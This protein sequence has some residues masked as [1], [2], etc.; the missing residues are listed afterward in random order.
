MIATLAGRRQ[1]SILLVGPESVGKTALV[2]EVAAR[3]HSG[4]VPPP[5]KD[6]QVWFVT[7]NDLI[8]GMKY[9]GEWEG[10]TQKLLA[11]TRAGHQILYMD[12]PRQIV[13]AGR[14]SESDNNMG[15]FLRPAIESGDLTVICACTSEAYE[16]SVRLEPSF[17]HAFH[18]IDVPETNE[19]DTLAILHAVAAARQTDLGRA[20]AIEPSAVPT[21]VELTRR[22]QPYRA[23]PGKA[24]RL[25]ED[26]I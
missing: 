24:V 2:H 26:A 23:F 7:A 21:I 10:R 25:L 8:A 14:W 1:A 6:R 4:D 15:R 12:D 11:Q 16:A 19:E 18:R 5:L 13:T 17:I 3:I 22:F 20:L 9:T